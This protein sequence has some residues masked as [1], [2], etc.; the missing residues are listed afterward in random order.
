MTVKKGLKE[1]LH[2]KC[3][4]ITPILYYKHCII[5]K[6]LPHYCSIPTDGAKNCYSW[7]KG[8]AHLCKIISGTDQE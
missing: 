7:Y 6:L 5:C 4:I 2:Y 1:V 8:V 3:N